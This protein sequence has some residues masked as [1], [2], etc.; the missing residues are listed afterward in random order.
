MIKTRTIKRYL[1][2]GVLSLTATA[3]VCANDLPN[4]ILI[5]ADDLGYG[6]LSC[7]GATKVDAK[8]IDRLAREG[9]RFTDAHTPSAVCSPTRYG[10]LTGR[11]PWR[12][13]KLKTGVLH[14][15]DTLSIG[16]NQPT[17]AS[18]LK[19]RGYATAAVGK[20][21]LGWGSGSNPADWNKEL[22]PGPLEV[23][24]DYFFGI[25]TVNSEEPEVF[26][27]NR[28]V[29]GLKEDDPIIG[30]R[31]YRMIGGESA[32]YRHGHIDGRHT[33]K[34]LEWLEKNKKGPFF[35][36][37]ATCA[38]HTPVIPHPRFHQSSQAGEYGDFIQE[39]D[40]RVGQ[41]LDWLDRSGLAENTLVIYTS[42]NG[43][44]DIIKS[45]GHPFYRKDPE[46]TTSYHY[47]HYPN[48][49]V[50]RGQKSD[51]WEG[52]HRV[53]MIVRWPAQVEAGRVADGL[54]GLT[55]VFATLADILD[56]PLPENAAPD[57]KSFAPVI[58]GDEDKPARTRL[59]MASMD[60]TLAIR[61]DHWKYIDGQGSGGITSGKGRW[62][63]DLPFDEN[64][65]PGQLFDLNADPGEHYNLYEQY[66]ERVGRMKS[67]LREMEGEARSGESTDGG[68]YQ[69][70][71]IKICEVDD[72]GAIIWTRLTENKKR[73]GDDHPLP[74]VAY[75]DRRTGMQANN[76]SKHEDSVVVCFPEDS[77]IET[78]EGAVPGTGGM[79]NV[80]CRKKGGEEWKETGWLSVDPE[81]DFTRQVRL[82]G[83]KPGTHYEIKV[84]SRKNTGSGMGEVVEGQFKTAPAAGVA[85]GVSFAVSTGQYYPRKDTLT[86]FRIYP[87]ILE[88]DPDFFVHTGDIV[89]YDVLGKSVPLAR[90]HWARMY[91][92]P[93]HVEFHRNMASYFIKDDHDTWMDDC[94]PDQNST[95]M[96]DLTFEQG[97]KIFLEQVGMGRLTYRTVRWGKDLQI[98]M[99]EG[100]DYRSPNSMPDGPGKTIW[101]KEQMEW[102]RRTVA[103]SDAT[104]RI[105]ISPTPVVGPDRKGKNDNHS[106]SGF[107]YEGDKIRDFISGQKNMFVVCGDR[108]WQYVS[109]DDRT[110]IREYSCGPASDI[111]AGGWSND[112]VMPEHRYLN[113]TGGFLLV[114]VDREDGRPCISFRHYGVDGKLLHEDKL[115]AGCIR[116]E[117]AGDE[118][119]KKVNFDE[120]WEFTLNEDLDIHSIEAGK[121][122]WKK[123]CLPH[124]WSIEKGFDR[125]NPSGGRGGYFPGGT[126]WYK[127]EF[128][129]PPEGR[130][131]HL[132]IVFDGVYKDADIWV[133]GRHVGFH[134][135]GYLSFYYDITDFVR[136]DTTNVIVLRVDNTD[137]PH[138]RWYSG[139]GIYRHVWLN[140]LSGVHIPV[141]GTYITTPRISEEKARVE[142]KT[143]VVNEHGE[144]TGCRI[145]AEIRDASGELCGE[146]IS[147]DIVL[148]PGDTH[149]FVQHIEVPAP[150]LWSPEHPAM[151]YA[152]QTVYSSGRATDRLS[153][154]FGIRKV[155]F[156]AEKGFLLNGKRIFLA[157]VNN[158]HDAGCV[159]AAVPERTLYLRL[160]TLKEMG[161][162]AIR[163]AHNPHAPE[164]LNMCDTM[165]IL[166]I[167]EAFDKWEINEFGIPGKWKVHLPSFGFKENRETYLKDFIDRDRNHPA[168]I[169]WSVGNEV[170]EADRPLGAEVMKRLADFVHEYEPTRCVS[171]ALQPP[172]RGPDGRPFEM[173][174][175]MDVVG[176][177][178]MNQY[179][180]EDRE[181]YGFVLYASEALARYTRDLKHPPP[182][183]IPEQSFFDAE[184]YA[185]G[186]FIW[187]GID[188]LGEAVQP[189]PLKGWENG[190]INTCGFRKP[191]SYYIQSLYSDD[192]M[193]HIAVRDRSV[194]RQVGKKGW[195][196]PPVASHWNW[197]GHEQPLEVYT[198]TN[199]EEVELQVNGRSLGEKSLKESFQ[200]DPSQ[201]MIVW[202]LPFEAGWINAIGKNGGKEICRHRLRTAGP[203]EDLILETGRR[204]LSSG[205]R[206][207]AHMV[208]KVTD[209]NGTLV[210]SARNL[211]QFTLT[212]PAEII[213]V[214]NGDLWSLESY[215]SGHR[216]TRN[217]KC[218]AVIRSTG[219]KGKITFQAASK[220]FD[221]VSVIIDVK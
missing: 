190:L 209:G 17:I 29:A 208:V 92:Q 65:P 79:V 76:Y 99:V 181:K 54:T 153:T 113:V 212:G 217:G 134:R 123:V 100:R 82:D 15:R 136:T 205:K 197:E 71:G 201:K 168:V 42:D 69:A 158:H 114:E 137:L 102:F 32:R 72:Q 162:K 119:R 3:G 51:I 43:G 5:L 157:G 105:L 182:K 150:D 203:A 97:Q 6:D 148:S 46:V 172:G 44:A 75:Y 175:E 198:Y 145:K 178:Y 177:N 140:Y 129:I 11:Y 55:D 30:I 13:P 4:I 187:T 63:P 108:H 88:L 130:E 57:S 110:G 95:F 149:R 169:L 199:C 122:Y 216:E 151:Y 184:K 207:A 125:D 27:E 19:T 31:G 23:G 109:V 218:L 173:A 89:Y 28:R 7:Y 59:I 141:W 84:F 35:L 117:S 39:N 160:K 188:Y 174:F 128:E 195:D 112:Q 20:W 2:F 142:I 170:V 16:V 191:F 189:W 202:K 133:N 192:S 147:E 33:E 91:S 41:I 21:H 115:T 118:L 94:W 159:G 40:W 167:D 206:E 120:N 18:L 180:L 211:I 154:P 185:C 87:E 103:A 45:S 60:G 144:E 186:H 77:G 68:P 62:N 204:S 126:G 101:G 171:A 200:K 220:G 37:F 163:T 66:P 24:F 67:R 81:R 194:T 53:P 58:T 12:Y 74:V 135:H 26:V 34:A 93:T 9:I 86:G 146:S 139:C 8:N 121:G 73:L 64:E 132:L 25:P 14:H 80:A 22:K 131:R 152:R 61:E 83:L 78:I 111:H 90:W 161:C 156:S 176:Y 1:T 213:G 96:G 104:F 127:R 52:G 164:L 107:T 138:D 70:T 210:P 85:S 48:G 49:K 221:P 155:E 183:Y 10:L 116:R 98:W 47:G 50:L 215:R 106:N 214:D 179:F 165:G 124:D 196:W 219:E 36:Y 193:V 38:V 56:I 166:I 143:D